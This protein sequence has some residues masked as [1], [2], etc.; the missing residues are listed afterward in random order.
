[1]DHSD[2]A[3]LMTDAICKKIMLILFATPSV[4]R[5]PRRRRNRLDQLERRRMQVAKAAGSRVESSRRRA[6]I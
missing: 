1:M 5:Q 4:I 6:A 2:A 3:P